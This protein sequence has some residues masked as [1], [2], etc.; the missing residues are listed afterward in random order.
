MNISLTKE[1]LLIEDNRGDAGLIQQML[2][3]AP[4]I[5]L[6]LRWVDTLSK[7]LSALDHHPVDAI[8]LDLNLPDSSGL[9]TFQ[10]VHSAAP[11]VPIVV[12]TGFDDDKIAAQRSAP[13]PKIIWSKAISTTGCYNGPFA[14]PSSGN[15]SSWNSR[16][17]NS[18]N[19]LFSKLCQISCFDSTGMATVWMFEAR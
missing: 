18:S 7:G 2:T 8:L 1:V 6:Q 5:S 12:L 16:W 15:N 14:T 17:P 13:G 3:G 4:I 19:K 9:Q 11:H 10:Q